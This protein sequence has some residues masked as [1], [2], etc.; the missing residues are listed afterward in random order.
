MTRAAV[1]AWSPH[2]EVWLLV[3]ALVGGYAVAV[4]RA[5]PRLAPDPARPVTRFQVTALGAA[6]IALL[7]ASDWPVH[8]VAEGYLFSVHMVQHLVYSVLVAPLLLMAVPAWMA[9]EVLV[10]PRLLG[11]VRV[12]ARFLPATIL[13]NAVL[14]TTHLP[15][16]V[17]HAV[18]NALVHFGVHTVVLLSALV[19]WLPILSPLPEVPRLTG[20]AAMGFL[21]LQSIVPT[22]PASWLTFNDEPLYRVYATFDRLWGV[23]PISDMRVAGLVMK[24]GAGAILWI[25]IAI[26]FFRWYASEE[27]DRR[28]GP[29][30]RDLDRELMGLSPP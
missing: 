2:P 15:P 22:V 11:T 26:V 5:G 4:T 28:P 16:V 9:R 30:T 8:D 18:R 10:R 12:L 19:V 23:T 27:P 17:D 13:F 29:V 3:A 21:F 25:V 1:P 7:V 6:A 24:T 14:V 20:L